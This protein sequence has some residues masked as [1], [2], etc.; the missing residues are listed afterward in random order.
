MEINEFYRQTTIGI[1]DYIFQEL[2]LHPVQGHYRIHSVTN[3]PRVLTLSL[4]INPTYARKLMAMPDQLAMAAR[5]DREQVIQVRRGSS[6]SLLIEIPKPDGT[7]YALPVARLRH[8]TG[9]KTV[10]GIDLEFRSTWLDFAEPTAA[11]CLI[12]GTIGSGKTNAQRLITYDLAMQNQ[13]DQVQFV[14]IDISDKQ[15]LGFNGFSSV[16][17]LAHPIIT[18]RQEAYKFFGWLQADIR[19]RVHY[20]DFAPHLFVNIE[21]LQS[22]LDNDELAKSVSSVVSIAREVGVHVVAGTQN[23]VAANLGGNTTVKRN[24]TTRLVGQVDDATAARVAAGV[25]NSGCEN[26]T[27]KG[28]MLL[29]DR[30][31]TKR[32]AVALLGTG[33]L[34][35]LP[36]SHTKNQLDLDRYEDLTYIEKQAKTS[37]RNL[38]DIEPEHLAYAL[39]HPNGSQRE[40]YNQFNIGFPKIKQ[41]QAYAAALLE[42]MQADGYTICKLEG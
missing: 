25:I 37:G 24:M 27:G 18:D 7:E 3:C 39:E 1:A 6:G 31:R 12:A 5:L 11:N 26:L 20:N 41:I 10:V 19:R 34:A 29:V 2:K 33:D 21:E 36:V 14:F 30:G 8:R 38:D 9:L 4:E 35:R 42:I 23:P 13:P 15:G 22:L 28:D 40:M 16:P 32:L 17:H